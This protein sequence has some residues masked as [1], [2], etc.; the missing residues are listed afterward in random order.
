MPWSIRAA[1]DLMCRQ[2]HKQPMRG[3]PLMRSG[4]LTI[5]CDLFLDLRL[6]HI[7]Q[8]LLDH[9]YATFPD[10][11]VVEIDAGRGTH[12]PSE[13]IEVY[14]G[15]RIT[16]EIIEQL[17]RLRWIHF[18]SVGVNRA[19]SPDVL[20]RKIVV[21]NSKGVMVAPMVATTLAFMCTL[22][23]GFQYCWQLRA[24]GKLNRRNFDQHFEQVY[25]LEGE[26]CAIVGLGEIGSRL[27]AVCRALGMR[28]LAVKRDTTSVRDGVERLYSLE[29]LGEAVQEADYVINLLP[30]IPST[31]GVFNSAIFERMKAAAFF[32]SMG[33]GETVSEANLIESLRH[34]RIAGAGLDVFQDEPLPTESPLWHMPNV[35]L[36][37]HIGGMSPAY[38]GREC[39][40]MKENLKRYLHHEPLKNVVDMQRGY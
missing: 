17:P 40:L 7:P 23:R 28:V 30:L 8:A 18:A 34:H 11:Q 4:K 9:L 1:I 14:W 21:T 38:W 16:S 20:K 25:D 39:A 5:G 13:A 36:T 6:Y 26:T 31:R 10:I 35:V 37:P 27:S 33:R 29:Q 15:N 2:T 22:A 12:V 32:I 24:D 3:E 19:L